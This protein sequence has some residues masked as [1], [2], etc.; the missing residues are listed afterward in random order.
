MTV[1]VA[2]KTY[3]APSG[4][5][6]FD[7][8]PGGFYTVTLDNQ[9]G[10]VS[11]D[12]MFSYDNSFFIQ[13]RFCFTPTASVLDIGEG[14]FT[15]TNADYA[16]QYIGGSPPASPIN[17][18]FDNFTTAFHAPPLTITATDPNTFQT[19]WQISSTG[20]EPHIRFFTRNGNWLAA[21]MNGNPIQTDCSVFC[22]VSITGPDAIC[23]NGTFS[24][25]NVAN[26]TYTWSVDN[27]FLINSAANN[28]SISITRR[29]SGSA[30]I[31]VTV[32]IN[33]PCGSMT[34]SKTFQFGVP[35]T[36]IT[37]PYDITQHTVMGVA[38]I[39]EEYY[40]TA[41]ES[42][43]Y[44]PP[45]NYTWTLFP[46][47]GNPT[48]YAGSQPYITFDELGYHTLQ[49]AKTTQCGTTISSVIIDVQECIGLRIAVSP[50]PATEMVLVNV[51]DE[52]EDSKGSN[53]K[54]DIK[55]ELFQFNT[56]VKHKQWSVNNNQ[57][58]FS[59]NLKGINKGVYVL[60]ITKGK[61]QRSVKLIVE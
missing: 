25:P 2:S 10:S 37:G 3:N 35:P 42:S 45:T 5:L 22:G 39:N 48:L 49:V 40:F 59:L 31:T 43:S 34:V 8:Y 4:L 30:S 18:P 54:N 15:L 38:C 47:V 55:M 14:N 53:K 57:K 6:P 28:N 11:Q 7:T 9:P 50:N 23:D 51:D 17:S 19:I 24:V 29:R 13:R 46:P 20:D 60:R 26:T 21:E 44:F 52:S 36:I 33:G 1:T 12:W 56:G 16:R 41:T 61:H 58:Q 27:N 32:Q